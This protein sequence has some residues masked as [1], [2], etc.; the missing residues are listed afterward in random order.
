MI[1]GISGVCTDSEC[2][3]ELGR[4]QFYTS[5]KRWKVTRRNSPRLTTST[6]SITPSENSPAISVTD[7]TSK[8]IV[9]FGRKPQLRKTYQ[10]NELQNARNRLEVRHVVGD[11]AE[12]ILR[13]LL[14]VW[15]RR[16]RS[17]VLGPA[18]F[19]GYHCFGHH[20]SGAS[21]GFTSLFLQVNL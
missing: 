5:A 20:F 12:R 4:S 13:L 21:V 8:T 2:Q 10:L 7:S 14:A 9:D 6:R 18:L 19:D 16:R 17:G 11:P 1:T 15:F 3:G